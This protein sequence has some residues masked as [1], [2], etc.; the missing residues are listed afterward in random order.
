MF[1]CVGCGCRLRVDH[2]DTWCHRCLDSLRDKLALALLNGQHGLAY[3][4][5]LYT[6][7]TQ[8]LHWSG[9]ARKSWAKTLQDLD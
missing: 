1:R 3:G 5:D 6:L 4:L 7:F 9:M 2:L 8:R